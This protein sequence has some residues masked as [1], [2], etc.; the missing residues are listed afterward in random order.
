MEMK[1]H[2]YFVLSL[3]SHL[4]SNVL[5]FGQRIFIYYYLC[6]LQ[7]LCQSNVVQTFEF[8]FSVSER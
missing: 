1:L 2:C 3:P 6:E 7:N 8:I 5:R 4:T